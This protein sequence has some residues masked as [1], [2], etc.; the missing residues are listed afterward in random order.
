MEQLYIGGNCMKIKYTLS[1]KPTKLE[2]F[3]GERLKI[4]WKLSI[5]LML[6]LILLI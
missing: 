4:I 1:T 6:F 5:F 2:V 3:T